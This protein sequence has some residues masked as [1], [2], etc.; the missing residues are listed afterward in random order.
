MYI[1]LHPMYIALTACGMALLEVLSAMN[2]SILNMFMAHINIG[3]LEY[4]ANDLW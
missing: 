4:S 3:R 1:A 2:M